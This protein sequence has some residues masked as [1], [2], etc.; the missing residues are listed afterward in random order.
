MPEFV[1]DLLFVLVLVGAWITQQVL[2]RRASNRT[3]QKA[4]AFE[5]IVDRST[6]ANRAADDPAPT[7]R[8]TEDVTPTPAL[9]RDGTVP[10]EE[11]VSRPAPRHRRLVPGSLDPQ[12]MRQAI[13]LSE[14]LGK[15]K[16][17]R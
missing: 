7:P 8:A 1:K 6:A 10:P 4:R 9:D 11:Q 3:S 2:R 5:E 15:P 16:S 17:L 12:T 14:I 13:I